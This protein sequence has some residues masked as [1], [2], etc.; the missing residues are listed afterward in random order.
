MTHRKGLSTMNKARRRQIEKIKEMLENLKSE[1]ENIQ[2]EIESIIE[3]LDEATGE[4]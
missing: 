2:G 3:S 4:A 1:L